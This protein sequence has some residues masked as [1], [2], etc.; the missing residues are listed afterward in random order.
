MSSSVAR[1]M[2]SRRSSGKVVSGAG[3]GCCG[4]CGVGA[5][6][7]GVLEFVVSVLLDVDE[8]VEGLLSVGGD[9]GLLV[10]AGLASV[11]GG[12]GWLCRGVAGQVCWR[13]R[14]AILAAWDAC[15]SPRKFWR[16]ASWAVAGT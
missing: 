7:V 9:G 12:D 4:A 10:C 15:R 5:L 14:S 2:C 6:A 11:A 13:Q 3:G 1:A 8:V 16:R